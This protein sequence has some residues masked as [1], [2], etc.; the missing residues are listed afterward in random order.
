MRHVTWDHMTK[1]L[2]QDVPQSRIWCIATYHTPAQEPCRVHHDCQLDTPEST[3]E[4]TPR[5]AHL[6]FRSAHGYQRCSSSHCRQSHCPRPQ[7]LFLHCSRELTQSRCSQDRQ[8]EHRESRRRRCLPPVTRCPCMQV[9][10]RGSKLSR[11]RTRMLLPTVWTPAV[12][13]YVCACAHGDRQ[14]L[15]R[16]YALSNWKRAT[17]RATHL[18]PLL[19]LQH[20]IVSPSQH[21]QRWW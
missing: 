8:A 15:V 9:M 19:L 11:P 6:N 17:Q 13:L 10:F 3:C 7:P 2:K 20:T 18:S 4:S 1:V 5:S 21:H 14:I 16:I 12:S